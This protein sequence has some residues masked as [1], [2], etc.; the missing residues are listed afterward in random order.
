MKDLTIQGGIKPAAI[1]SEHRP[2]KTNN[3]ALN[4]YPTEGLA[5]ITNLKIAYREIFNNTPDKSPLIGDSAWLC[6]SGSQL[7]IGAR[8]AFVP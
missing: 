5:S 4:A 6:A 7:C 3:F 2:N 1:A 8:P